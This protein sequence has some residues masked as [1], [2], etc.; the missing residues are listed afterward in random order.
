MHNDLLAID[1]NK[2]PI[3]SA[4][5][6]KRFSL[7]EHQ[8]ETIGPDE[9]AVN[10]LIER[11]HDEFFHNSLHEAEAPNYRPDRLMSM[12]N[13][14][15]SHDF[16]DFSP[17][18][19]SAGNVS[20]TPTRLA[21]TKGALQDYPLEQRNQQES[22]SRQVS[23]SRLPPNM[24]VD[25]HAD[26]PERFLDSNFDIN[27]QPEEEVFPIFN[28]YRDQA[29]MQAGPPA[30]LV[31]S[32]FMEP[33]TLIMEADGKEGRLDELSK[34]TLKNYV[35]RAV[36][37]LA[38]TSQV[39]GAEREKFPKMNAVARQVI[40]RRKVGLNTAARKL[41]EDKVKRFQPLGDEVDSGLDEENLD[42]A[43]FD[44]NGK[45]LEVLLNTHSRNCAG[46]SDHCKDVSREIEDYVKSHHG[47]DAHDNLRAYSALTT[48]AKQSPATSMLGKLREKE[49]ANKFRDAFFKSAENHLHSRN[50][51]HQ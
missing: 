35:R 38:T 24:S 37:D 5:K 10:S 33:G 13:P 43:F 1:A 15:A 32:E 48:L 12:S 46:G 36:D 30:A 8:F 49:Q 6:N 39:L 41:A 29:W 18:S 31:A 4:A 45:S 42:E 3:V 11:V 21:D 50:K 27:L 51:A 14:I 17:N 23:P 22:D 25:W 20:K 9:A 26:I 47:K 28:Q 44:P 34:D 40:N 19:F 2:F 16:Q 7:V